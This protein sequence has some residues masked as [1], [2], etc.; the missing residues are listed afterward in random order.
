MNFAE[1]KSKAKGIALNWSIERQQMKVDGLWS[2]W[3][4]DALNLRQVRDLCDERWV[5][6]VA[7]YRFVA[8]VKSASVSEFVLVD[9]K[10]KA[11]RLLEDAEN[12]IA[13]HQV[14]PFDLDERIALTAQLILHYMVI[15]AEFKLEQAA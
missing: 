5:N 13:G 6:G 11:E 14:Q 1:I 10:L 9:D 3:N 12:E 15:D 8:A 7:A 4:A 2:S